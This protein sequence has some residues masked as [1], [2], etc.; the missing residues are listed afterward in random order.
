[1]NK[2]DRVNGNYTE[3]E[4]Y[5]EELQDIFTNY[6]NDSDDE[7]MLQDAFDRGIDFKS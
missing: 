5:N 3:E 4:A 2:L 1:M 6:A 7:E